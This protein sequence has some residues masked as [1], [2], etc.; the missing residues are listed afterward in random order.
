MASTN[1]KNSDSEFFK[2]IGIDLNDNASTKIKDNGK[3]IKKDKNGS[4]MSVAA[5]L[6]ILTGTS[7]ALGR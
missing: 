4:Q 6:F 5:S 3:E 1:P 2:S 7:A